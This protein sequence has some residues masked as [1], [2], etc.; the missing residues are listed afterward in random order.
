MY[1]VFSQTPKQ[2]LTASSLLQL[3]FLSRKHGFR[4]GKLQIFHPVNVDESIAR[5]EWHTYHPFTKSFNYSDEIEIVNNQ[6][7]VFMDIS[8]AELYIEATF[9]EENTDGKT[10]SC[11]L[12]NNVG[13]FLFETITYELNGKEIEKVRDPGLTSTVKSMLCFNEHESRALDVAGWNWPPSG[14]PVKSLHDGTTFNLLIPLNFLL[15]VF[16]E[17]SS[18]IMG[19]QKL[20]LVRA[21][22]D[23]NCY[24]N[25]TG[26]KKATITISSVEL[27]IFIPTTF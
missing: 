4:I 14:T 8:Q 6:Q 23:D 7:D 10:G 12:A 20:K 19:K 26:N 21:R 2:S 16:A 5:G 3:Q 25:S 24:V 9:N 27:N 11:L 1:S 18:A 22:N 15:G 17:Y 13:A